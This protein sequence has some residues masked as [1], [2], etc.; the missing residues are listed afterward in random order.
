MQRIRIK[1]DIVDSLLKDGKNYDEIAQII[2][3]NRNSVGR[4]CRKHYGCLEDRGKSTRQSIDI[5]NTQ[6]QILFGG[7]LGD[8]C[9]SPH[10]KTFRGAVNHSVKQIEYAKYLHNS[11]N[12]IV[13]VFR[14]IKVKA[15]NKI[16]NECNFTIKPNTQLEN[17]YNDFYH[18]FLLN[19]EQL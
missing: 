16:Y 13:G 17:L 6:K 2:G 15:N 9:L 5:T 8:F 10:N 7:L 1:K 18:L 14:E 19:F 11:L 12:N 4:F 3:V